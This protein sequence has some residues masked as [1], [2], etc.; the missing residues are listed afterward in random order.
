MIRLLLWLS[1]LLGLVACSSDG[2]K[3]KSLQETV[4]KMDVEHQKMEAEHNSVD[5]AHEQWVSTHQGD[6]KG[7]DDSLFV[8]I[9]REH[10][11]LMS[12]HQAIIDDHTAILQKEQAF[13][14][15]AEEKKLPE[16]DIDQELGVIKKEN[17]RMEDDHKQMTAD[18]QAMQ[19]EHQIIA[20]KAKR[21]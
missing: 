15:T 1:P 2:A 16:N 20:D 12:K 10:G 7:P 18:H 13:L 11:E 21:G 19:N 14:K 9:K 17:Q 3:L 8:A 5:K 6:F 4:Q